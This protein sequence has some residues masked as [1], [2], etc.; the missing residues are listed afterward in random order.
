[1]TPEI[2]TDLP[3]HAQPPLNPGRI[4]E[5]LRK[6][7]R[8]GPRYTS[9][10]PATQFASVEVSRYLDALADSTSQE[11]LSLYI[12]I[13]FCSSPCYYCGCNKI[14]TRNRAHV[15]RYMEHLRREMALLRLQSS[16]HQR[17]VMQ[18]HLGGGTPTFLDDAELTE[19]VHLTA[20]Y[21][22]LVQDDTRDYAIEID[23][24]TVDRSRIELIRG[25]GFNR[26]S[27]G[28]Q[29]FDPEV[30]KAINRI[31]GVEMIERLVRDIRAR[32]FGSLNFDLIYGLPKQTLKSV[33]DTLR[34]VIR[35]APDRIS[36][37]NY[38]HLPERFAAQRA[39]HT[40]DLPSPA[41]KLEML[42]LLIR[43]L[44]EAGYLYIGMDHFVKADDPLALAQANGELCRNFQGYSVH[45]A[46][47]LVGLGVSSISNI[48]GMFVQNA[49]QLD[50]YY[51]ALDENRL[52]VV[53]GRE[54]SREDV[55]RRDI[56]QQLSCYRFLDIARIERE[57]GI[58]FK[59]H[60]NL[61][62]PELVQLERDG[63]L[64]LATPGK[65]YVSAEGSLL[66]RNICMV[67]DEYLR[68]DTP[69]KPTFS[70]V[71]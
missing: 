38:A 9:Y 21:F 69:S 39:I 56:I 65:I 10:P 4:A 47:D 41:L 7:D 24:R 22:R 68:Q 70:R 55:L 44:T 63:L 50:A 35:L 2:A 6:Y 12:H 42:T 34:E 18:L 57:Y 32:A 5:L 40:E 48:H 51:Q 66:L 49:A 23:P 29:D 20:H 53:R 3:L 71:I 26:I 11:P 33:E 19:L 15:R 46:E 28:I 52:P 13:P 67:F 58:D 27:L 1:M 36:Y 61:L 37:Y 54:S 59:V 45:K 17:P 64:S 62:L 16:L 30:Q 43:T 60:F 25:L 8:Q 14:V 31:Q